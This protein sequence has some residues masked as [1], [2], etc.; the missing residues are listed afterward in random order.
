MSEDKKWEKVSG[1]FFFSLYSA[2]KAANIHHRVISSHS[3]KSSSSIKPSKQHY[4]MF[5][6]ILL[7]AASAAS[8]AMAIDC[9]EGWTAGS[10]VCYQ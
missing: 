7:F 1:V 2:I 9:P 3:D 5:S 8:V 4:K 6:K 10:V